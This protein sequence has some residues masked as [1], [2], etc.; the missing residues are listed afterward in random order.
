MFNI[1]DHSSGFK[2][3]FI[4]LKNEPFRLTEFERRLESNFPGIPIYTVTPEDLLISK[5]IWIQEIQSSVQME[6][7]KNLRGVENLDWKYINDWIKI[8]KLNTFNLL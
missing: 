1:I 3:D 4:L 6:D 7:I 5:L 2:A 8:L